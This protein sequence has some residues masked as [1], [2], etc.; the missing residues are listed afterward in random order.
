MSR[1]DVFL[2]AL[3]RELGAAYYRALHGRGSAAGVTRAAASVD[4]ENAQVRGGRPAGPRRR[5]GGR[6]TG[7][8]AA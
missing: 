2:E 6:H 1:T 3:A 7:A 4:T 5:V 8:A